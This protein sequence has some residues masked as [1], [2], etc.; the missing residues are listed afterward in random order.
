ML[1]MPVSRTVQDASSLLNRVGL[2]ILSVPILRLKQ[3]KNPTLRSAS[4]SL[5]QTSYLPHSKYFES[6]FIEEHGFR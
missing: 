5:G 2:V 6:H 4:V 3:T 1:Y